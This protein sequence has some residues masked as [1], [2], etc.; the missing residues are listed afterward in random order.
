M[1]VEKEIL[2]PHHGIE[3]EFK[4]TYRKW[5]PSDHWEMANLKDKLSWSHKVVTKLNSGFDG[6]KFQVGLVKQIGGPN[7]VSTSL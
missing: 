1:W 2:S 4:S 6:G 3:I 5:G 7:Q